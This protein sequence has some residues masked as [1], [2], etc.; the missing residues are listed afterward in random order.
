MLEKC[1]ERGIRNHISYPHN[2]PSRALQQT[3]QEM[4]RIS[5]EMAVA[6][7]GLRGCE[8]RRAMHRAQRETTARLESERWD[9][10]C[11]AARASRF[12]PVREEEESGGASEE[13]GPAGAGGRGVDAGEMA[14][15]GG[16]E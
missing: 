14:H 13:S 6:A 4:L 5:Q 3:A 16:L 11:K 7:I 12:E 8:A 1:G 9:A 2:M 15:P 10:I